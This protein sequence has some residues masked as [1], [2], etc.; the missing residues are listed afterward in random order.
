MGKNDQ[1]KPPRWLVILSYITASMAA[2]ATTGFIIYQ[3]SEKNWEITYRWIAGIVALVAV[4]WAITKMP[5]GLLKHIC[6]YIFMDKNV[7]RTARW[8]FLTVF[9][10]VLTLVR[11]TD[12][13]GLVAV[14]DLVHWTVPNAVA[15]GLTTIDVRD[16]C[17]MY[18]ISLRTN[19]PKGVKNPK[20]M[21]PEAHYIEVTKDNVKKTYKDLE[22]VSL[23]PLPNGEQIDIKAWAT[24]KADR[25]N[26]ERVRITHLGG[27]QARLDVRK[28]VTAL[29][30]WVNQYV[31]IAWGCIGVAICAVFAVVKKL[32]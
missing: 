20:L 15:R 30:Q 25:S 29:A 21:L 2:T 16:W 7:A 26:A 6:R 31:Y 23:P 17:S 3:M 24:C 32:F 28:P 10:L 27:R 9:V 1:E 4:V 11:T 14:V 8:A 5:R 22:T 19:S 13:R 12:A 18:T